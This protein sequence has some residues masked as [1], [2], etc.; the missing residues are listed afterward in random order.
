M[1]DITAKATSQPTPP[2][3]NRSTSP[4]GTRS[5]ATPPLLQERT[6]KVGATTPDQ[7]CS[8]R[9]ATG[10]SDFFLAGISAA[11]GQWTQW[12]DEL[13]QIH[14]LRLTDHVF[15][16]EGPDI[17]RRI[18]EGELIQARLIDFLAQLVF[19]HEDRLHQCKHLRLLSVT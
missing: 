16:P 12:H 1:L 7:T 3:Q 9:I 8:T 18:V 10:T 17:E 6:S 11:R 4:I 13:G 15:A 19:G 2:P 14:A 5:P